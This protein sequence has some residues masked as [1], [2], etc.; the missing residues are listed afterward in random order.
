MRCVG[1]RG[2]YTNRKFGWGR[3]LNLK[4]G[5][6]RTIPCLGRFESKRRMDCAFLPKGANLVILFLLHNKG[7]AAKRRKT[8]CV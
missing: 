2:G 5:C 8:L 3:H 1:L 4:G 6:V 7:H